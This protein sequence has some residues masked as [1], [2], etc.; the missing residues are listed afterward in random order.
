M[1]LYNVDNIIEDIQKAEKDYLEERHVEGI[2]VARLGFY[3]GLWQ[4]IVEHPHPVKDVDDE[5]VAWLLE[6]HKQCLDE[7]N[8]SIVSALLIH[9]KARGAEKLWV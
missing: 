9:R 7:A 8:G 4:Y 5:I 3:E 1:R 6:K 2:R